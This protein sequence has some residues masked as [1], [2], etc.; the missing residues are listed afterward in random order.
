MQKNKDSQQK[1]LKL[2]IAPENDNG[3][4]YWSKKGGYIYFLSKSGQVAFS[5][6]EGFRKQYT[7]GCVEL[8]MTHFE[9]ADRPS[10]IVFPCK[11]GRK[12]WHV[13]CTLI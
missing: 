1:P 9:G 3:H 5:I 13:P 12:T 7:L 11:F 10:K 4:V 6:Q 2:E 8:D